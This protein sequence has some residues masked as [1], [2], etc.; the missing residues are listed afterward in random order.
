MVH[1][2]TINCFVCVVDVLRHSVKRKYIT[3]NTEVNV[4]VRFTEVSD[5]R[6]VFGE[7]LRTK[8]QTLKTLISSLLQSMTWTKQTININFHQSV[9]VLRL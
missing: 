3:N 7:T 2:C 6:C 4:G 8:K 5:L 9:C 1:I